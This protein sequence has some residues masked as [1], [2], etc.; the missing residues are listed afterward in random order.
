MNRMYQHWGDVLVDILTVIN[1]GG[2]IIL[3][4]SFYYW[5]KYYVIPETKR[6]KALLKELK[7]EEV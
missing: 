3:I 6:L 4:D 2:A 1:T 7:K 5:N